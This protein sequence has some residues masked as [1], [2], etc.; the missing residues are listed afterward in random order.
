V[1]LESQDVIR[2]CVTRIDSWVVAKRV[3]DWVVHEAHDSA[4]EFALVMLGRCLDVMDDAEQ[5]KAQA[6]A[7]LTLLRWVAHD[8]E[9]IKLAALSA[10]AHPSMRSAT[11]GVEASWTN[12]ER[13]QLQI[14]WTLT[15][16]QPDQLPE[17]AVKR[18]MKSESRAVRELG[19][20]LR[21]ETQST[22]PSAVMSKFDQYLVYSAML[23]HG[24]RSRPT[25]VGGPEFVQCNG[26]VTRSMAAQRGV[27]SR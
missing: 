16:M 1:Q 15:A 20:R 22:M 13:I 24:V 4:I 8:N 9:A 10:L 11:S 25:F 21:L 7:Q 2:A 26:E 17:S 14:L 19:A 12:E 27:G 3:L 23:R 18:A 6:S 5:R